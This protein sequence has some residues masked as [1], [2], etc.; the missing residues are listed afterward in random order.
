MPTGVYLRTEEHKRKSSEAAING[1]TGK[2][3]R[4]D[5]H[6]R[7]TSEAM[8]GRHLSEETKRKISEARKGIKFSDE[9]KRKLSESKRNKKRTGE[10]ACNWKGGLCKNK[11]YMRWCW[12]KRK[13]LKKLQNKNGSSHTFDEWELLKRQ[14]GFRCPACNRVEPKIKLTEDHI[15]P[16]SKM[17]SDCIENIQ[18]LCQSCNSK[19]HTKSIKYEI[20]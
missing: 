6:K 4:T 16:L 5:R 7:I 1:N 9:H 11:E 17:G 10:R 13:R 18:P 12:G 20:N 19:K 2:Y 8:K 3:R 15:V 14:Y